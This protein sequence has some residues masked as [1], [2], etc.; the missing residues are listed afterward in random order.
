M[1][2]LATGRGRDEVRERH[3]DAEDTELTLGTGT[4]L[5]IFFW[6][7][8]VCSIFF[9][10]GYMLG[11]STAAGDKTQIVGT[12]PTG[13][14][15]AGKPSAV[16]KNVEPPPTPVASASNSSSTPSSSPSS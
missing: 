5:G 16:N 10:L 15:S 11:R 13:S 12:A 4:L 2:D 7:V 14:S 6:L 8:I 1:V 3:S 9:T